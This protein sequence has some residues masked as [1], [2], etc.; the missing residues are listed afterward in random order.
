MNCSFT[1]WPNCLLVSLCLTNFLRSLLWLW[2]LILC[3][4]YLLPVRHLTFWGVGGWVEGHLSF[5]F[6]VTLIHKTV[7]CVR[8]SP[9]LYYINS[10]YSTE[11][12]DLIDPRGNCS[13]QNLSNV[14]F[15][16]KYHVSSCLEF[17]PLFSYLPLHRVLCFL[18][19][20]IQESKSAVISLFLV[21]H[22]FVHDKV[23]L[24]FMCAYIKTA[25]RWEAV[26]PKDLALP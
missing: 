17:P 22:S 7:H 5:N 13:H 25:T 3:Y 24:Y 1:T 20:S 10:L 23:T 11:K 8:H 2:I 16:F 21:K 19:G 15:I 4:K 26:P 6:R 9:G 18:S 14:W 12:L